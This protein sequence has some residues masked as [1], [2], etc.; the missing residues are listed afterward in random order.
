MV[1]QLVT[2]IIKELERVIVKDSPAIFKF[3]DFLKREIFYPVKLLSVGFSL[4]YRDIAKFSLLSIFALLFATWMSSK[5]SEVGATALVP[6]LLPFSILIPVVISMF[7][8]PSSYTF[9][10]IKGI[11]LDVVT[12]ILRNANIQSPEQI[13]PLKDSLQAFEKRTQ[14]RIIGLRLFMALC[15]SGCIY[16]YSE[17]NKLAQLTQKSP[18]LPDV[19]FLLFSFLAILVLY[20]AIE[21]YSKVATLIFRAAYVGCNEHEFILLN[22]ES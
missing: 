13:K 18:S 6:Y 15:W 5:F 2:T 16:L 12:G 11:H 7:S 17:F 14:V 22:T 3:M 1:Y 10:G 20:V 4:W 8:A 19:Y 21:S 9:C